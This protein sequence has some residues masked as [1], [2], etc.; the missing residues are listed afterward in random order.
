MTRRC[1][2]F[3]LQALLLSDH[4]ITIVLQSIRGSCGPIDPCIVVN[5][6]LL[7]YFIPKAAISRTQMRTRQNKK[8]Y[9]NYHKPLL[10]LVELR[11]LEPLTS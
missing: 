11:G 9:G 5:I 4:Y 6:S 2:S 3:V 7:F 8:A 10:S 1:R